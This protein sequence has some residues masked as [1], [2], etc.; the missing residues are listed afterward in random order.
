[1][2]C[3]QLKEMYLAVRIFILSKTKRSQKKTVQILSNKLKKRIS[4]NAFPAKEKPKLV[5]IKKLINKIY[6]FIFRQKV[7]QI[8]IYE[9][10]VTIN[11]K[12]YF[13]YLYCRSN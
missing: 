4:K 1:M 8:Y 13:K 11:I 12:L 9:I 5:Q 6:K 3:E 7:K 10:K 2:C